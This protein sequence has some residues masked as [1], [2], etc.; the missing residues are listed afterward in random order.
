MPSKLLRLAQIIALL[1]APLGMLAM[2][3]AAAA[4]AS[5]GLKP[6]MERQPHSDKQL[7]R[8]N[9]CMLACAATLAAS[10]LP[11]EAPGY[12]AFNHR[13]LPESSLGSFLVT[14]PLPPP[15]SATCS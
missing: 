10:P 12:A 1:L 3:P 2:S 8:L 14:V 11:Q 15:R 9:D 13:E 7:V 4:D 5:P 6:C